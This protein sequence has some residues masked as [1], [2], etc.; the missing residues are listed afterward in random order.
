M[1]DYDKLDALMGLP[2]SEEMLGAY[3]E[4]KLHGS[5]FREVQN[6]IEK[7]SFVSDIISEIED[8]VQMENDFSH[9]WINTFDDG[10]NNDFDLQSTDMEEFT[11]P[12]I[13]FDMPLSTETTLI[14]ETI[15]PHLNDG[16]GQ[17]AKYSD[18]NIEQSADGWCE[19]SN[20]F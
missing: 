17:E 3:M 18:Y 7:D 11:L 12:E 16:L 10:L 6:T 1:I 20:D 2:V 19:V 4:G 8:I 13:I 5:D 15:L 14:Q 9:S